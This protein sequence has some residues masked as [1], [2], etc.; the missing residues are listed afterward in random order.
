VES[1]KVKEKNKSFN[2]LKN[3]ESVVIKSTK[4]DY[5]LD[6]YSNNM[7]INNNNKSEFS[8]NIISNEHRIT[9]KHLVLSKNDSNHFQKHRNSNINSNTS[10]K[11]FFFNLS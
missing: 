1:T 7:S 8:E 10:K 9:N 11:N 3:K 6:T 4:K 5:L 2:N